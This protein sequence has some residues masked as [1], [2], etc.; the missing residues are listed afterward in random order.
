MGNVGVRWKAVEWLVAWFG[1]GQ[2]FS[3]KYLHLSPILPCLSPIRLG[4]SPVRKIKHCYCL[5]GPF[6]AV[7]FVIGEACFRTRFF[8][9]KVL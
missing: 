2:N 9:T 3:A 7:F 5:F 6:E 8:K 1:I 4:L